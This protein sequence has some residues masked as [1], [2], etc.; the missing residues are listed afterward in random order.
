[1]KKVLEGGMK[2][3]M[4]GCREERGQKKRKVGK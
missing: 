2:G 1:M 4:E 3:R